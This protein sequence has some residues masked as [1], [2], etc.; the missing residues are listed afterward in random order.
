MKLDKRQLKVL[1][2]ELSRIRG[3]HTELVTVY[4]PPGYN[5][6]EVTNQIATE[7]GTA[8]NIKS[9]STRKN[10]MGAL[11]RAAQKLKLYKQTPPNGL[12]IFSGNVSEND[13]YDDIK[14]WDIE[15]PEPVNIRLYRC[16]STFVLDPLQQL[17]R[18]KEVYGL[19]ALDTKNA[20]IALLSGKR[21]DV[22]KELE[23]FVFGKFGKGGQSAQRFERVRQGLILNFEKQIG[24]VATNF[25]KE[26]KDLIGI[27][28]GGPG[29]LKDDFAVNDF[30]AQ[31]LKKKILAIKDIGYAGVEGLKELVE[32]SEDVLKESSLMKEKILLQRFFEH[33]KKDTGLVTYGYLSVMEALKLGAVETVVV[34]EN[35]KLPESS[36]ADFSTSIDF[37]ESLEDKAKKT[38]ASLEIVS[39]DTPEGI[40]FMQLGGIGATL[41]Y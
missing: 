2:K 18:E 16:D 3:R 38:G 27:I 40:Q 41:R 10:V 34:S 5:I 13:S 26:Q 20:V 8:T 22:L 39:E 9:K 11:E 17:I 37:F 24:E 32:R 30:L 7:Q 4:V 28:I 29:P 25:F 35:F 15:P 31:D 23:A 14:V 33:L 21:I 19:I 36:K 6:H 1:I 12:V